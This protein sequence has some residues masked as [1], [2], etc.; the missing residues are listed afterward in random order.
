MG[1]T[2]IDLTCTACT[3]T[4]ADHVIAHED[5]GP[6]W[7][8]ASF[9]AFERPFTYCLAGFPKSDH[10]VRPPLQIVSGG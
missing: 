10:W 5:L 1:M 6:E 3:L 4:L 8:P 9:V 7:T 2:T